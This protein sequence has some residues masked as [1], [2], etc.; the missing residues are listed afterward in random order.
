MK[1]TEAKKK[2]Q[3]QK[4]TKKESN[5]LIKNTLIKI[6]EID[7][8]NTLQ[9]HSLLKD[10]KAQKIYQRSQEKCRGLEGYQPGLSVTKPVSLSGMP[11]CSMLSPV[12]PDSAGSIFVGP[13]SCPESSQA[14]F[15]QVQ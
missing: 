14:K 9:C 6:L 13:F 8:R 2:K 10:L 4:K 11:A 5:S 15:S 12:L 3:H 1:I 7:I